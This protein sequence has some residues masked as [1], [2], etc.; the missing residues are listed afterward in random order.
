MWFVYIG[1]HSPIFW[2]LKRRFLLGKTP[3]VKMDR[4]RWQNHHGKYNLPYIFCSRRCLIWMIVRSSDSTISFSVVVKV[5]AYHPSD[6]CSNPARVFFFFFFFFYILSFLYLFFLFGFYGPSRLFHS[7][8]AE[9]I[10]RWG[11]ESW[12][13]PPDHPRVERLVSHVTRDRL[14]SSAVRCS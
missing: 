4:W 9:S 2:L 8:W 11:D 7:F 5:A 1:L 10:V 14:E 3:F 12:D 13:K 6:P